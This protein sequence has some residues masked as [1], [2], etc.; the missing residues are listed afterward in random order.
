MLNVLRY[1]AGYY[2]L[3]TMITVKKILSEIEAI[4]FIG[5]E[6]TI[7]N[8]IV[9]IN[10]QNNRDDVIFWC[11]DKNI[12]KLNHCTNGTIVCSSKVNDTIKLNT[13][14]NYIIVEN[15][16]L[17]FSKIL[18]AF[19]LPVPQEPIISKNASIHPSV[20]IGKNV[21]IGDFTT[22]EQDC[23]IGD[24]CYIGYNNTILQK[25]IIGNK[26]KIGSNNTIGGVG[27]GYEK[28][29]D[30]NYQLLN[31]I[32]NVIINDRVEIGNNTCIDRAVLG[33]TFI[34]ENVKIDNLVH[35]AHGVI[36]GK[37][38]LIIANAMLGGSSIIGEN[39]WVAPSTSII[40]K[41][42]VGDDALIGMGAV[43][44]K[45]VESKTVVVGN[46]AVF[47]KKI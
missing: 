6:N 34:N 27:F 46:P 5:N 18:N 24:D 26:V 2:K 4:N 23:V 31:H 43:V 35:I 3:E 10:T 36:I 22:I 20:K 21:F 15:P 25:T 45:P 44:I 19:F 32:G 37:N 29:E 40:N 1:Y 13:N 30:G 39:V 14:C 12:D 47:L 9:Q 16:R 41:G 38:S 28:D 11:N 8:A 33:S 42:M 17:T 7:V